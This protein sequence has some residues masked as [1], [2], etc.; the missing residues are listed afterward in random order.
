MNANVVEFYKKV[1]TDQGLIEALSEGK[2]AE[3]LS[4]IAVNKAAEMGITLQ[5]DDVVAACG[6]FEELC[7]LAANDDE[8][9]EF[10]LEVIAGG[11][12]FGIGGGN[13]YGAS[14]LTGVGG[15]H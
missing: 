5:M 3:E 2:T 10:E 14:G 8:L 9:T 1:R 15:E 4:T 11:S 7:K 6:N 13:Y 12:F